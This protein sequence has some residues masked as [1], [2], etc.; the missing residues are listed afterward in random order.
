MTKRG[1]RFKPI[2]PILFVQESSIEKLHPD[3]ITSQLVG[4]KALGLSCVPSAWT[5]PFIV[6]S[7]KL[8]DQW[9]SAERQARTSILK[10]WMPAILEA[11]SAVKIQ[12]S[13][14]IIVRSSGSEEGLNERGEYY[15][16]HGNFNAIESIINRCLDLFI[17]D[18]HL[19]YRK[20]C[21]IVQQFIPIRSE[22]GHLSNER[23]CFKEARD[24][25]IEFSESKSS[26][27]V[28]LR[29]W[30]NKISIQDACNLPLQCNCFKNIKE[31]LKLPSV[32]AYEKNARVHYEWVWDRQ[33]V[34]IVQADIAQQNKGVNPSKRINKPVLNYLNFQPKFLV[35]VSNDFS[36]VYS[37]INNI[38]TY[39]ELGLPVTKFY[40]LHD[41][42]TLESIAQGLIPS[43]LH[44]DLDKLVQESLV[45]RMD[46]NSDDLAVRQMLP[47]TNEV[48]DIND[49]IN[50]LQAQCKNKDLMKYQP[51]FIFHNFVPAY[52]SA[53]A[54]ATPMSRNVVVHA[55]WGLPEGLYYNYFDSYFVDTGHRDLSK[56]N[57]TDFSKFKVDISTTFKNY[58]VSPNPEGQ[59]CANILSEPY[60][61]Q[62]TIKDKQIIKLIAYQS[63]LIAEKSNS[64]QSIMWLIGVDPVFSSDGAIPWHHE[65]L[66][67]GKTKHGSQ[68]RRKTI[69]DKEFIVKTIDD[70]HD[71][72]TK[73]SESNSM[74]RCIRIKPHDDELLRDK[75]TLKKIGELA[76]RLDATIF[77]DGSILSHAYY[78]LMQT[79]ARVEAIPLI[80]PQTKIEY[81]KLVR[82]RVPEKISA[83]GEVVLKTRFSGNDLLRLL[84]DKLIEESFEVLDAEDRDEILDEL[85][86]VNEIISVRLS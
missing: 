59:W 77:L 63:R 7:E 45:I 20:I 21:L 82:D 33:C 78:Q 9:K 85:A 80:I 48:R 5:L 17:S 15:S 61:W 27:N 51:V 14:D 57:A 50:W 16:E 31:T 37:K 71:L 44:E 6:I 29:N 79:N 10:L 30:R 25:R 73:A 84:K 60:D 8:F 67:L 18:T 74:I 12:F 3:F 35:P 4:G 65:D 38:F 72:E 40:I 62:E 24:W 32:L 41:Q 2:C 55:L 64:S 81:N 11:C 42:K 66:D 75:Y 52:A 19:K 1:N 53:F 46:V 47:R 28:Y 13:N 69:L 36:K 23:R 58:F 49:A 22:Y 56:I 43:E 34:Y 39:V 68:V 86:D 70:L 26:D 54:C 83:G 76:V